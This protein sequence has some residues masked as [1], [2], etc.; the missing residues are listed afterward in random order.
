MGAVFAKKDISVD[1]A[2]I[3]YTPDRSSA[4][5]GVLAGYLAATHPSN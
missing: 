1:P 2:F 4:S 5:R 3:G